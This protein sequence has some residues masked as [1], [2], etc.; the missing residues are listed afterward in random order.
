MRRQKPLEQRQRRQQQSK[1]RPIERP[2]SNDDHDALR[3]TERTARLAATGCQARLLLISASDA[4]ER[5]RAKRAEEQVPKMRTF[6]L[7]L[8]FLFFFS[9]QFCWNSSNRIHIHT[10]ILT[11]TYSRVNCVYLRE[12]TRRKSQN[13]IQIAN[14]L[15]FLR[16]SLSHMRHTYYCEAFSHR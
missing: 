13:R 2:T 15:I 1:N 6:L 16:L 3:L 12:R 7:L 5:Q 4:S 9:V 8:C 10:L 11:H 14:E